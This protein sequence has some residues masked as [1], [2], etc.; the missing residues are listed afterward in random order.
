[1]LTNTSQLHVRRLLPSPSGRGT[2]DVGVHVWIVGD[3][4]SR[5]DAVF[6]PE[7]ESGLIAA[8]AAFD[9]L[10]DDVR[11]LGHRVLGVVSADIQT[12][13]AFAELE[14]ATVADPRNPELDTMAKRPYITKQKSNGRSVRSAITGRFSSSR[15]TTRQVTDEGLA[16]LR[17]RGAS[18]EFLR[19]ASSKS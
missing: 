6:D 18:E 10:N 2:S 7:P 17:A 19:A 4:S 5:V 14:R 16:R 15:E 13:G 8:Q 9:R 12:S 3:G 11:S 1:M